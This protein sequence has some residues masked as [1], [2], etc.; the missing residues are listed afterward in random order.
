MLACL[1]VYYYY[2]A[3]SMCTLGGKRWKKKKLSNHKRDFCGAPNSASAACAETKEP[4]RLYKFS[5]LTERGGDTA[6][7]GQQSSKVSADDGRVDEFAARKLNRDHAAYASTR[8]RRENLSSNFAQTPA[9]QARF[10]SMR[11]GFG[12]AAPSTKD[13]S[14]VQRDENVHHHCSRLCMDGCNGTNCVDLC[15]ERCN[16]K[17]PQQQRQK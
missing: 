7:L 3:S 10:D 11:E 12:S 8:E 13:W 6:L 4:D 5:N 17:T 2:V 1:L 9:R 14:A 16:Q 15:Q